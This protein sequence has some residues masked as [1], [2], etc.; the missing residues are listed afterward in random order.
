MKFSERMS[1]TPSRP[2]EMTRLW[3]SCNL[4]M[5]A[6]GGPR[7]Q[8]MNGVIYKP[9]N[10]GVF[11]PSETHSFQAIGST[12]VF[13]GLAELA[14]QKVTWCERYISR[15]S[16]T[17]GPSKFK[18]WNYRSIWLVI[19]IIKHCDTHSI[20]GTGIFTYVW[21]KFM[22]NVGKCTMPYITWILWDM[23]WCFDPLFERTTLLMPLS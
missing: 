22:V 14:P 3:E 10:V 9:I 19:F 6:Q 17:Q 15:E 1:G 11:H 4:N 12:L 18:F 23:V 13:R 20:H 7:I 2:R 21:L 16:P 5:R 8:Q